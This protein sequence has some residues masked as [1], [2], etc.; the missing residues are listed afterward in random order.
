[1]RKME[2]LKGGETDEWRKGVGEEERGKEKGKMGGE[3]G[4]KLCTLFTCHHAEPLLP[5]HS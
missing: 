4:L 5:A 3:K 1:M 2:E